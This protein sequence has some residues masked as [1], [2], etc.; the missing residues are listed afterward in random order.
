M[1]N[2]ISYF[3]KNP[4]IV[5][6]GTLLF[7]VLG[8]LNLQQT[9]TTYF[10]KEKIKFVSVSVVYRGASPSEVE[11]GIINKIEDNLEGLE[12]V[13]RY[14]STSVENRGTVSVELTENADANIVLQDVKNAV[15]KVTTFPENIEAPVTEKVDILNETIR[16]AVNGNLP[17][18]VLKDYA[19]EIQDDLIA[20]PGMSQ[21][22]IEGLPEEEI[23]IRLRENDLRTY[24]LT[25]NEVA[26]AV[27]NANLETSGGEIKTPEENFLIRAEAKSYYAKD[28]Q[29]IVVRAT[30]DG[31]V[32]Q[33]KDVADVADQ[34]SDVPIKRYLNGEPSVVINVKSLNNEDILQNAEAVS[35]YMAEFN[36]NHSK[37]QCTL[38]EDNT[39]NLKDRIATLSTNGIVGALL[40]L[41]VLALFLNR[42]LAFWVALKIPIALLG[43]MILANFYDLTISMVSLFGG[44]L[45]LGI[46]VDDGVVVAENIYQHY[47]EKGKKPYQAALDG[48]VEVLP[49]VF[50]SLATTAVAFSL[51]FFIA[52]RLGEFFSD[53]AFVVIGTLIIA[54]VESFLF[55]PS[56]IAHSGAMKERKKKQSKLASATNS[57]LLVFRDRVYSPLLRATTKLTLV[58]IFAGVLLLGGAIAMV[59][60]GLVKGTFFPNIDQDIIQARL[61]LP[62]GTS[63]NITEK[64]LME[65]AE[66]VNK[67]DKDFSANLEGDLQMVRNVEIIVGP[68]SNEG[69]VN[70]VLLGGERRGVSSFVVA[71]AIRKEVGEIPNAVNTSYGNPG[72]A[73]GKPVSIALLGNNLR[74]LRAAEDELKSALK[75]RSDLKDVIDT[76][77]TGTTEINISLKPKAELLGLSLGQV[78]NQVRSG[79]FGSEVQSLQRG[80]EEIKVW[81]RYGKADRSSLDNLKNM[82]IRL[83]GGAEYPLSELA[84]LNLESGVISINHQNGQREIRVESDVANLDVPVPSVLAEVEKG[85]LADV[86]QKYPDISYSF[87][88]QSRESAKTQQSVATYGPI[89]LITMIALIVLNFKSFSQMIVV[90]VLI[91]FSLV[92]VIAGHYIHGISLSIFSGVGIIALIG[93]LVNNSLVLISGLNDRLRE[94]VPFDAAVRETAHS[95]FR[96][97]VLTT[98]TTVAGL[99]PLIAE[100]SFGAQ[101]LKPTAVTIAYGLAFGTVV[102]L[103]LLPSLLIIFNR[104]KIY[105]YWLWEGE[106]RTAEQV[107]PAVRQLNNQISS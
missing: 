73:F 66:A 16:F 3:I 103:V 86:L 106:K 98:I 94:G 8:L 57:T 59:G 79:F 88:G 29:N 77:K 61:E 46:L 47:K 80:D 71:S 18:Q 20:L 40:V 69:S 70:V 11:E 4:V 75:A 55:L 27:R 95:R 7:I 89:V 52:G 78:M 74:N 14:T 68:N 30:S 87:E 12:G 21:V 22:F 42:Y 63:E 65:I 67:V 93:V 54:L 105:I 36:A 37:V 41:I 13:Q 96:A 92:G 101:F 58:T 72:L 107:E 62:P 19:E 64:R 25:F 2:T 100:Q 23:E 31:K 76:D 10:P 83:A 9:R 34:F 35:A 28:L 56:H 85:V 44:I 48:T 60:S 39:V 53:V 32:V 15:E 50:I 45:V 38:I 43:M 1:R 90:L 17:L 84:E 51:F 5:T 91:P 6:L 104:L 97:I 26:R 99:G 24:N 82:R 33:L 49:A 102:T 81:L